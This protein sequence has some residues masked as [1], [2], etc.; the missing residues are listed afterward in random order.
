MKQK[1]IFK[2]SSDDHTK[3]NG[4]V[5]IVRPLTRKKDDIA[6]VGPMFKCSAANGEKFDAYGDELSDA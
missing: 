4:S 2:S 1:K 6:D 5:T 3:F